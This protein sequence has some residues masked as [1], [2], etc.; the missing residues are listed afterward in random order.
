MSEK[1]RSLENELQQLFDIC[2]A[3]LRDEKVISQEAIEAQRD[4]R[5]I[6]HRFKDGIPD[7]TIPINSEEDI[8]WDSQN[9]RLLLIGHESCQI[10]EVSCRLTMIRIRPHLALLVK[11]A[12]EFYKN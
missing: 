1:L 8:K 9:K 5:L 2:H 10:L 3:K 6:T 12:I 4:I 11:E 7:I